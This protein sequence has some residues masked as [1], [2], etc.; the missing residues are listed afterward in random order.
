MK[1]QLDTAVIQQGRLSDKHKQLNKNELMN[2]I[3]FG[4]DQIFKAGTNSEITDT[5]LEAILERGE[6]KTAE[7]NEKLVGQVKKSLLDFSNANVAKMYEFEGVDY[8]EAQKTADRQAW[9]QMGVA[10]LE[11]ERGSKRRVRLI[12]EQWDSLRR[13]QM[14]QLGQKLKQLPTF[15]DWQFFNRIRLSE[16]HE[17]Q[18]RAEVA[19]EVGLTDEE[20]EELTIL[21]DEGFSE[22]TRKDFQSFIR[23]CELY[24]RESFDKICDELGGSKTKEEVMRYSDVFWRRLNELTDSD[25]ILRRVQLGEETIKKRKEFEDIIYTKLKQYESPWRCLTICYAGQ[26]TRTYFNEEEDRWL[27]NMTPVV[28]YGNWE[29]L[30]MCLRN[31]PMWRFDWFMRSRTPQELARRVDILIRLVRKETAIGT[32][33]SSALKEEGNDKKKGTPPAAGYAPKRRSSSVS[34]DSDAR[35][36]PAKRIKC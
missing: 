2:M 10:A 11:E 7:Q 3:Q 17:A 9:A 16:L 35:P 29:K 24:G 20:K 14:G 4:A 27:L 33:K 21:L 6:K 25:K 12:Q 8:A 30:R 34:S 23:G 5:D 1:L 32:R 15:H 28:G 18:A 22:W 19:N 26:K 31:D 36:S 13:E